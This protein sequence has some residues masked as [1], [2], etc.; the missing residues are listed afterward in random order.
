MSRFY[1]TTPIYY[2]NDRPHIGHVYTTAVADTLARYHRLRGD[3][4]FFLTGTDEHAT[5]VLDSAAEHGMTPIEWADRNAA[6]FRETFQR[7]GYSHD[8]FVRTTEQRHT[9]RVRHYVKQL[10]QSGDVYL[11]EYEG[12]YDSG[13]EEYVP[14]AKAKE[15]DYKSPI[16]GKPLVRKKEK[17]YFFRLSRYGDELGA[18]LEDGSRFDVRPKAR[19]NEVLGR[20]REG[21]NDVPMSRTGA[22][23]WGIKVP[24]DDEHTIY[25]WI[26][27]L[28]NYLS[29]MDTDGRR[30][31]W[32][33]SVHLIAKDILWFHAVVWPALLLALRKLPGND[34]IGLPRLVYSHSFW[35]REG[36]KMSKSLG[37][38][39]DLEEI[40]RY[41]EAF[42]LDGFRF[43][44][45][46]DGPLGTTDSDF[47][48]ERF[49]EVYNSELANTLGNCLSR[50]ASMTHS[51]FEG[52]LPEKG[53]RV[54]DT[55]DYDGTAERCL[56]AY[57][58][59]FERLDLA[60]AA[61]AA[62]DLVKAVDSYIARTGPFKLAKDPEQRPMVGSILYNSAEA[63][64]IAALM[65]WPLIPESAGEL[66]R[67]L[68]WGDPGEA[69]AQGGKGA[70]EAWTSWGLLEAGT[71]IVKGAALF[72]RM[73]K[74]RTLA[75]F[76]GGP[77]AAS[78]A[79]KAQDTEAKAAPERET[80]KQIDIE[81][82]FET[83]LKVGLVQAAEPVPKSSKLLKLTVD[84]GEGS[85]RTIVAGIAKAYGPEDLVGKQVV[86]VANLKPA[87]LM[88]VESQGMVLAASLDG[89]PVVVRPS[90]AVPP[91]TEVR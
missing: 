45:A 28:F 54:P 68:G 49:I 85:A 62:M 53:P 5:K 40:D 63:L 3:D 91:G 26:D 4:V 65:L 70:L 8:D 69:V 41:V 31:F 38:F 34:W 30:D 44:L 48:L 52:R 18:L 39:I 89:R 47:A 13:Q 21:L 59:A 43:F 71:E 36:Q 82:F 6:A 27:A 88:G 80:P 23:D 84:V 22:E 55:E 32:P 87:K 50:V 79:A 51:Y 60:A 25:V 76:G 86:V 19:R 14:E 37:N 73:D 15:S 2:V 61:A 77:E 46:S 81:R 58:R 10:I 57:R 66:L 78:G 74:K 42:G 7:L 56:S 72:P 29:I 35:I 83:Q 67:R 16:N 11:G 75:R 24:G 20:I 17:N 90:E 33:A 12:W 64:R 9:E 1:V